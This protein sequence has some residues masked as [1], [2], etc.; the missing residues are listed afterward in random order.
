MTPRKSKLIIAARK[1][2]YRPAEL[3]VRF[4]M[5][6]AEL[7]RYAYNCGALYYV[8]HIYLVNAAKLK[9]VLDAF[10]KF[11]DRSQGEY[12]TSTKAEELLGIPEAAVLQIVAAADCVY[13]V[14]GYKLINM[15]ELRDYIQAHPYKVTVTPPPEPVE[16]KL[17]GSKFIREINGRE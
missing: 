11:I 7:K 2:F 8:H 3:T 4:N 10:G 13:L 14:E 17:R 12:A 15:Q 6:E 9:G 5:P 16:N 1:N